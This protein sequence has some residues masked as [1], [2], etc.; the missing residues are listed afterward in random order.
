MRVGVGAVEA[1]GDPAD[2]GIAEL[3]KA[4]SGH[5]G[6]PARSEGDGQAGVH[7]PAHDLREIRAPHGIPAGQHEQWRRI[8]EGTHLIDQ[9]GC[10]GR[11][12]LERIAVRNRVGAAVHTG[13]GTRA[14]HFPDH[15][16]WLSMEI[17]HPSE[18][19]GAA[20]EAT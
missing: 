3:A 18:Y 2:A 8:S 11:A 10:I 17:G 7:C 15:D 19:R 5:G 14:R 12:E 20:G 6:S 1:H 4:R 9:R 16:E 13:E